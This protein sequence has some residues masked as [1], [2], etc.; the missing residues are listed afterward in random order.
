M[1]D[2][3]AICEGKGSEKYNC[4]A[5]HGAGRILSRVQAKKQLSADDFRQQ[6]INAGIYTST[7]SKETLDE[8]PGAYK[9]MNL[10]LD[11]IKETVEVI[12]MIKPVYNFKA[13]KE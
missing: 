4:S 10:I 2:G 3:I 11:N 7:A 12:E 6:M 1:R 13:G 9:D 8:A 5:P